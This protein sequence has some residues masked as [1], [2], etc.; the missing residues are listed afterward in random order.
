MNM[1]MNMH[2]NLNRCDSLGALGAFGAY[3]TMGALDS[4][5]AQVSHGLTCESHQPEKSN[6]TLEQTRVS[7]RNE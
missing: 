5:D 2:M 3:G 1:H 4:L 7:N 6:I